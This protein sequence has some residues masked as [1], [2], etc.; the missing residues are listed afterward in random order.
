MCRLRWCFCCNTFLTAILS[1]DTR[2][3]RPRELRQHAFC[4][5]VRILLLR[6]KRKLFRRW[7]KL[8]R[9]IL[10]VGLFW[11]NIRDAFSH[12]TRCRDR[13]LEHLLISSSQWTVYTFKVLVPK[14]VHYVQIR[15][16]IIFLLN[17]FSD[18]H[19]FFCHQL[20]PMST[21]R[22]VKDVW[23]FLRRSCC[24]SWSYRSSTSFGQVD[25]QYRSCRLHLQLFHVIHS[26]NSPWF[27]P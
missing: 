2:F 15:R 6:S 9:W 4:S 21:A 20:R 16:I 7:W 19:S 13:L 5:S 14:V 11:K 17:F 22:W 25:K 1:I 12:D 23:N 10:G 24:G 3:L 26:V 27:T 18:K 8:G